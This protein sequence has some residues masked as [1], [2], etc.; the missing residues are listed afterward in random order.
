MGG[1][2]RRMTQEQVDDNTDMRESEIEVTESQSA[3][4]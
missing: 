1:G 3:S 2:K 4:C